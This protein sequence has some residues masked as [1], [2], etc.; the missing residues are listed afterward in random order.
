MHTG[1][2]IPAWML[3]Q[4]VIASPSNMATV[5]CAMAP[6]ALRYP[7]SHT[8]D[9]RKACIE[10]CSDMTGRP[11]TW[12][13]LHKFLWPES[14]YFADKIPKYCDP[15]CI[16][17]KSLFGHP[18]SRPMWDQKMHWCMMQRG[19]LRFHGSV[20]GLIYNPSL[21]AKLLIRLLDS[22]SQAWRRNR[23]VRFV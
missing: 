3:Y 11:H 10:L 8:R 1:D 15:V 2:G 18:G 5:N 7:R 6:C 21:D 9:A 13:R 12:V 23:N 22:R 14:R 17:E 20:H 16:L 19:F 4:D